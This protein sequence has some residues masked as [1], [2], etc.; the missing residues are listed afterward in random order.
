MMSFPRPQGI[1]GEA[2]R[3]QQVEGELLQLLAQEEERLEEARVAKS[4]LLLNKNCSDA[5]E[6]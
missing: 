5:Q 1:H 4:I 2:V 3:L 6:R